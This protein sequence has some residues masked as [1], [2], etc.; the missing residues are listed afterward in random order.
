MVSYDLDEKDNKERC[1]RLKF[2]Q[3]KSNLFLVLLLKLVHNF[4]SKE[5]MKILTCNNCNKVALYMKEQIQLKS[6]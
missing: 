5:K 4:Y 1:V 2:E 6:I 3:F